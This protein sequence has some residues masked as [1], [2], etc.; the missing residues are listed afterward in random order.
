MDNVETPLRELSVYFPHPL[1]AGQST[2]QPLGTPL[3]YPRGGTWIAVGWHFLDSVTVEKNEGN[4]K[5]FA[6]HVGQQ[7]QRVPFG[8]C[9]TQRAQDV[10]QLNFSRTL[11]RGNRSLR[12]SG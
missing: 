12:G 8:S 9:V 5:P 2:A 11:L 10:S 6:I 7:F 4:R 1:S 3:R